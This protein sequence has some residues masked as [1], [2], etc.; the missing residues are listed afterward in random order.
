M[1]DQVCQVRLAVD[2]RFLLFSALCAHITRAWRWGMLMEPLGHKPGLVNSSISFLTGYFANY[3][4][5]R[6][7]EVTRCG[8]LYRLERIPVNLQLWYR[9]RR[10]YI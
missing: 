4:V 7:G 9:R 1:L 2:C 10:K 8:T 6:M 5:P 3:I